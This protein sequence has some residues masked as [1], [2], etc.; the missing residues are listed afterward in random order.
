M[1]RE[2]PIPDTGD[3]R[4]DLTA[5]AARHAD[6]G[7]AVRAGYTTKARSELGWQPRPSE[8]ALTECFTYLAAHPRP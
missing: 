5:A 8:Q 6:M 7:Q 1:L 3:L 4:A 2:V